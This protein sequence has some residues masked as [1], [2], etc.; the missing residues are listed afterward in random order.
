MSLG[1]RSGEERVREE[2]GR[3]V[4]GVAGRWEEVIVKN[5]EYLKGR[6]EREVT[7]VTKNSTRMWSSR[8]GG[9]VLMERERELT[10]LYDAMGRRRKGWMVR[11][12]RGLGEG[13]GRKR[14]G[15]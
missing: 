8:N 15:W 10:E 5:P 2:L 13:R 1:T 4:D 11:L 14:L 7:C 9:E 12:L 6:D 3:I